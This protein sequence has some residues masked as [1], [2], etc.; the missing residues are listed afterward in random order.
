MR[1]D[2]CEFVRWKIEWT[3]MR[4]MSESQRLFH[5]LRFH[6]QPL[7][8]LHSI[9]MQ[10]SIPCDWFAQVASGHTSPNYLLFCSNGMLSRKNFD[11]KKISWNAYSNLLTLWLMNSNIIIFYLWRMLC[12]RA[13]SFSQPKQVGNHSHC[14]TQPVISSF[15]IPN[16]HFCWKL[17]YWLVHVINFNLV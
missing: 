11:K 13:R 14:L 2:W 6:M 16:L 8:T 7:I 17:V 12:R 10:K 9:F 5:C 4:L 15:Q 3:G 1:W